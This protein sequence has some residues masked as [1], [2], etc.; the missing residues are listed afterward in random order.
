MPATLAQIRKLALSLPETTEEAHFERTSFRVRGKIY[1]TANPGEPYVHVFVGEE[2]REPSLAVHGSCM[3]KL[4]WGG[5]AVGLRIHLKTVPMDAMKQLV[6][7]A[8]QAKAPR[9]LLK[10]F[11]RNTSK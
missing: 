1:V 8:W 9:N 7:A 5:K 3:Q 4:V 6:I 11:G 2:H 10:S